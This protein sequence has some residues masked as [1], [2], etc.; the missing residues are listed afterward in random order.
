M[1][2]QEI[3]DLVEK[4]S[5]IPADLDKASRAI[6]QLHARFINLK[7]QENSQMQALKLQFDEVYRDTWVF[8]SGK[9]EP[10]VYKENNFDLRL[11]KGDID[12][13]INADPELMKI[14]SK[15]EM[16]KIKIEAIDEFIKGL[17]SRQWNIKNI[18]DYLKYTQG[19]I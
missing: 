11:L 3:L 15:I 19:L 12:K 2:L 14:K 18:L 1:T 4:N 8:Y 10:K 6:P 16:Q 17:H 7:A 5:D 9:A 13:F